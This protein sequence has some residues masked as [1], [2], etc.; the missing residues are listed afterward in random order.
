MFKPFARYQHD[1]YN[2]YAKR[3]EKTNFLK[4]KIQYITWERSKID[5]ACCPMLFNISY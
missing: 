5:C 2:V 3:E 1:T 4:C